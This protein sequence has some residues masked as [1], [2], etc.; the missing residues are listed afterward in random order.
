MSQNEHCEQGLANKITYLLIGGGIGATLALLF[1]PK[2]GT[3]L[4][5]DIADVTK[6]GYDATIE[7]ATAIQDRSTDFFRSAKKEV[8]D[9]Y[10]AASNKFGH[11]AEIAEDV[12]SEAT[13]SLADG[14]DRMQNE[15]AP[16]PKQPAN[17]R[18]N[19]SIF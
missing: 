18:K 11:A 4:R 12:V 15:S 9:L 2:R 16:P 1:A 19:T 10:S 13:G 3:E 5:H 17:G 7:T 8:A 14:I 6:R